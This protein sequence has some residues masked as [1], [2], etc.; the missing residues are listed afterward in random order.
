M[1][2]IT[3]ISGVFNP[4]FGTSMIHPRT[5][6]PRVIGPRTLYPNVFTFL[7]VSSLNCRVRSVTEKTFCD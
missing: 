4:L 2:V 5:L 3:V 1:Y 6:R 7:Y